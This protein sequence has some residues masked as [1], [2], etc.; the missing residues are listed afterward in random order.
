MVARVVL[1]MAQLLMHA[2][3]HGNTTWIRS[4]A[5]ATVPLRKHLAAAAVN[6]QNDSTATELVKR[7]IGVVQNNWPGFYFMQSFCLGVLRCK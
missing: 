6:E 4:I 5:E 1:G 2:H 3:K 7:H